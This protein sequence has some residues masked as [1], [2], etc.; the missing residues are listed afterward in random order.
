MI[1]ILIIVGCNLSD[2]RC[3]ENRKLTIDPS[4]GIGPYYL[5][6]TEEELVNVLCPEFTKK[7]ETSWFSVKKLL[8]ILSRT[9][10]LFLEA[11]D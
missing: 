9:C 8:T 1:G 6:M 2:N 5:G 4:T 11:T 7:Q 10:H 3:S